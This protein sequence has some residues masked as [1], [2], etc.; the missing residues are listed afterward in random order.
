MCGI[1]HKLID[2]RWQKY[3]GEK[4]FK[5]KAD[6]EAGAVDV[7]KISDK[8]AKQFRVNT[9]QNTIV[10]SKGQKGG[11]TAGTINNNYYYQGD[12]QDDEVSVE[13]KIHVGGGLEAIKEFGSLGMCLDIICRS[14]RPA[15]VRKAQLA[16]EGEGFAAAAHYVFGKK[17]QGGIPGLPEC[18]VVDFI[19]VSKPNHENGNVLERD[20]VCHFI[21]PFWGNVIAEFL[22]RPAEDVSIRV[23]FFDGSERKVLEGEHVQST[24]RTF[25]EQGVK[26]G[27]RAKANAHLSVRVT[28]TTADTDLQEGQFNCNGF[29][30][31][32]LPIP[33][34]ST[35]GKKWPLSV[36][37]MVFE[38]RGQFTLGCALRNTSTKTYK[39]IFVSFIAKRPMP[40]PR[41]QKNDVIH[42]LANS[43]DPFKPG[44]VRYFMV[45][46]GDYRLLRDIVQSQK[47]DEFG[48][49]VHA[50]HIHVF[51]LRS[52]DI[53][54]KGAVDHIERQMHKGK[55]GP[56]APRRCRADPCTTPAVGRASESIDPTDRN[57]PPP[58][59]PGRSVPAR[60]RS[61]RRSC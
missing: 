20:D 60:A 14:K 27:Y 7:P 50:E 16:V 39:D 42:F 18:L 33:E 53:D 11:Q 47:A 32:G 28:T 26:K 25:F 52:P 34:N 36:A 38:Q 6:H 24:L 30:F 23:E 2:D 43:I 35:K 9:I 49:A 56:C 12:G 41:N 13:A 48:L 58:C 57:A 51:G 40:G 37:L 22:N 45:P 61:H 17:F 54:V 8:Q 1:H 29:S 15:K 59:R 10:I 46:F 21:L 4:L 19:R 5:M 44:D 31:T 3:P 55:E